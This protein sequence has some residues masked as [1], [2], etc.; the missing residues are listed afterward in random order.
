MQTIQDEA[1]DEP[2]VMHVR[3]INL[4]DFD[5]RDMFNGVPFVFKAGGREPKNIPIDAANHIFG[6]FPA[7]RDAQG[8]LREPDP[9]EMKRHIM[10]RW[11]WN[12]P[13]MVQGDRGQ[14]FYENIKLQPIMYR[15]V[16]IE[17]DA[18]GQPMRNGGRAPKTNKLMDAAERALS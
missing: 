5:I 17:V 8:D 16:P 11:G 12:T 15:M 4:N 18:E 9:V 6:W 13:D 7:Y 1:N 3:V 14:L 2:Q 10:R